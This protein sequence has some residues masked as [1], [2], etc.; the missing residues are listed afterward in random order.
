MILDNNIKEYMKDWLYHYID[1]YCIDRCDLR[2]ENITQPYSYMFY[3]KKGLF[4]NT[5]LNYI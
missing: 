3:M 1:D 5:F 4:N 2:D